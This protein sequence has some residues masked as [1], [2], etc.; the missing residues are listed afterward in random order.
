MQARTWSLCRVNCSRR[1]T[2]QRQCRLR[3]MPESVVC[4]AEQPENKQF[5]QKS[6]PMWFLKHLEFSLRAFTRKCE[7]HGWQWR[8]HNFAGMMQ[9][10]VT[11]RGLF[12]GWKKFGK[13]MVAF[14][15]LNNGYNSK[16]YI[17]QL[18]HKSR[19]ENKHN[20]DNE[21][22]LDITTHR[23]RIETWEP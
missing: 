22:N 2:R 8:Q 15:E 23:S 16:Q 21:D 1:Q 18:K 4:A 20:L 11:I 17:N 7:P 3:G 10:K 9:M 6:Q 13:C 5:W 19:K 14:I 12:A